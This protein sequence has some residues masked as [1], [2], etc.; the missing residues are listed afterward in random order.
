M[1]TQEILIVVI[2]LI[3]VCYCKRATY[4]TGGGGLLPENRPKIV[5]INGCG[6]YEYADE[7]EGVD[8]VVT[9]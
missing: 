9:M 1:N 7:R 3:V 2:L 4:Q 6:P 5:Y 8:F